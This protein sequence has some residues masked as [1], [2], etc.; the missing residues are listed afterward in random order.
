MYLRLFFGVFCCATSVIFIKRSGT[1]AVLLSALR[2]LGAVACL[3]PLAWSAWRRHRHQLTAAQLRQPLV[4]GLLL[5]VHFITWIWGARLTPAANSSLI[6]NLVPLAFPWLL[7]VWVGERVSRREWQATGLGL[8]GVVLLAVADARFSMRHALG[9]AVCFGS[10]LLYAAYLVQSRRN[11]DFPSLWL[12][13]TGVYAVAGLTCLGVYGLGVA[14]GMLPPPAAQPW[15]AAEW[16]SL[17]GLILLPTLLGHTLLN[18][19]MQRMRGQV[20]ALAN[21][22]QFLWAGLLGWIFLHEL[23]GLP[24][25]AAAT[26][27]LAGAVLV[28]R[29]EGGK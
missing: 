9:D 13:V 22:T 12:Y 3:T 24:F 1:D 28:L 14:L 5:A 23:P 6:V 27:V 25:A 7:Q 29:P 2:L 8:A 11:R 16:T 21:Q 18:A 19:A 10:M 17:A 15:T 26:L 4:P 20:V